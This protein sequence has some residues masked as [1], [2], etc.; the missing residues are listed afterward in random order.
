[1]TIVSVS[2]SIGTLGPIP[3]NLLARTAAVADGF[4]IAAHLA[5]GRGEIDSTFGT[6]PTAIHEGLPS[7]REISVTDIEIVRFAQQRIIKFEE[8]SVTSRAV[9][10][11]CVCP[12]FLESFNVALKDIA[13]QCSFY[14]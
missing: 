14:T 13:D 10:T 9:N 5:G 3:V 2:R 7:C 4:T 6:K 8:W 12:Q 11:H 1:M